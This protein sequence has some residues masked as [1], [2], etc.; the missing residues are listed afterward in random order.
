MKRT[1][2]EYVYREPKLENMRNDNI[3][4]NLQKNQL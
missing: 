4:E 3:Q 1:D 2:I